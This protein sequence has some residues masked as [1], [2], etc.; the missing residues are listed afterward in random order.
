MSPKTNGT[1]TKNEEIW[2]IPVGAPEAVALAV[3]MVTMTVKVVG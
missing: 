3:V 2:A 1:L